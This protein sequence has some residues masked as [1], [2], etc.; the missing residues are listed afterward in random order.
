MPGGF[1]ISGDDAPCLCKVIF[2]ANSSYDSAGIALVLQCLRDALHNH[3]IANCTGNLQG[4]LKI[5]SCFFYKNFKTI[6]VQNLLRE[7]LI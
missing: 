5:V 6:S 3:W 1:D 7:P 4:V 2:I